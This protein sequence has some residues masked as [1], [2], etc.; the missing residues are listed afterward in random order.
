[1]LLVIA[2][3]VATPITRETAIATVNGMFPFTQRQENNVNAATDSPTRMDSVVVL[4]LVPMRR[5]YDRSGPISADNRRLA[6][7]GE[8]A[9]GES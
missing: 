2:R 3:E 7:R 9:P 6:D 1:M 8:D 4:L 5:V